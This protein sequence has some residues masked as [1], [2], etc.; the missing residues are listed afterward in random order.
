MT[1]E[2]P[3]LAA[4]EA[5]GRRL[6]SLLFPGAVL[7]LIGPLG[8][9]KTHL[10]RAIAEGLQV[11][12]PWIVTSPTFV[13]LQEYR[14]RLAISH[15]DVYRLRGAIDFDDL[16]ARETIE[17]DGVTIIEWADRV[18][19]SLPADH[20]RLTMSVVGATSRQVYGQAFG[21]RHQELLL[22]LAR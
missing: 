9:G 2:L 14:G 19:A 8:A 4:T 3:S 12:D 17:G 22:Q 11:P 20:L 1:V 15:Y 16:G 18:A 6:G 7:A 13:L 21:T 10:T 5:F